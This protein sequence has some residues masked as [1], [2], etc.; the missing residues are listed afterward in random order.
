MPSVTF[1]KT[2]LQDRIAPS[3]DLG[4]LR[5]LTEAD[6]RLLEYGRWRWTRRDI[7]LTPE[8]GIV[9]LPA[10]YSSILGARVDK[11]P[12][13]IRA[14]E[15]EYVPGG[16]GE[17]ELGVGSSRLIDQGVNEDGLRQYKVTGHLDETD[18][19]TAMVMYAPVTLYDPDY[20]DSTLPEDATTNTLCPDVTALKLMMFGIIYEEASDL[21]NARSYISDAIKSLDN[22]EQ[23]QRGN[24][25]QAVNVR[26]RGVGVS[27]VRSWR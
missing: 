2:K 13:D 3:D 25:R 1:L 12:V 19:I 8:D 9:T 4:F 15:F 24:A 7:T 26:A 27:R 18:I 17:V 21:G 6:M 22:K 16:V 10:A 11:L 14:E 20:P 23:N 5:L